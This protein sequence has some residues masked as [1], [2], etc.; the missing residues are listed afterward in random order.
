MNKTTGIWS[1]F[2]LSM[3]PDQWAANWEVLEFLNVRTEALLGSDREEEEEI[4][5]CERDGLQRAKVREREALFGVPMV[6]SFWLLFA[7]HS[8]P[9]EDRLVLS[10]LERFEQ[11]CEYSLRKKYAS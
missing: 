5:D 11:S 9:S 3:I 4:M 1:A 8:N 2:I 6:F 10:W 7:T